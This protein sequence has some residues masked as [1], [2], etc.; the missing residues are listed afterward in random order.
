MVDAKLGELQLG[1]AKLG[2]A[3]LLGGGACSDVGVDAK[4]GE[5]RLGQAKLGDSAVC[6][7]IP[8]PPTPLFPGA[9]GQSLRG[10]IERRRRHNQQVIILAGRLWWLNS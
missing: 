3:F 9:S 1:Q 10:A 8:P 2:D 4:L 6:G 5:L 7:V